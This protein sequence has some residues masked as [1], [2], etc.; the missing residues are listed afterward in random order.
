M[1]WSPKHGAP[2]RDGGEELA[3]FDPGAIPVRR[4][5]ND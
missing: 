1:A 5:R 4:R 3:R 2:I